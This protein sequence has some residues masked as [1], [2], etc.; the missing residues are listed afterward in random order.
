MRPPSHMRGVFF[1]ITD[2]R[3]DGDTLI[4]QRTAE[5]SV[6]RYPSRNSYRNN[7]VSRNVQVVS[8]M[9]AVDHVPT[10]QQFRDAITT[11]NSFKQSMGN[12]LVL[13]VRDDGMLSAT[14]EI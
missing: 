1:R 4:L 13:A 9:L 5:R 12:S 7:P 11:V 3:I 6:K 2:A 8:D 14:M 10:I